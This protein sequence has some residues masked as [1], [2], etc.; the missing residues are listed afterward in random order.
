VPQA[1]FILLGRK[2]SFQPVHWGIYEKVRPEL[3]VEVDGV[4]LVGLYRWSEE[5]MEGAAEAP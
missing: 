1:Y 3:A 4:E 5:Q 2:A